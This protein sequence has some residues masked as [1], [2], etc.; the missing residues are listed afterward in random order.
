MVFT[1][2]TTVLP[3]RGITTKHTAKITPS[4]IRK[5]SSRHT[6]RRS[7][8]TMGLLFSFRNSLFHS[9]S[10]GASSRFNTKA[11]TSP[12]RMGERIPITVS[13]IFSSRSK[14]FT[15]HHTS[16][17]PQAISSTLRMVFRFS[18]RS[19]HSFL[20]KIWLP[21]YHNSR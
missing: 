12:M 1:M 21:V 4:T 2:S 16:V 17:T 19:R 5:L 14:W 8:F 13:R 9:R 10:S 18:S 6:G 20:C 3:R 11:R 7:F 15:S